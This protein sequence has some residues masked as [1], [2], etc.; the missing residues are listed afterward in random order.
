MMIEKWDV[1]DSLRYVSLTWW[2]RRG[3]PGPGAAPAGKDRPT[4]SRSRRED[5]RLLFS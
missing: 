2:E 4:R 1:M 5:C 3:R